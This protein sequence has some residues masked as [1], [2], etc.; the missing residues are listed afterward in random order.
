MTTCGLEL[1][2]NLTSMNDPQY[3]G[4][5]VAGCIWVGLANRYADAILENLAYESAAAYMN[6]SRLS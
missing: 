1:A 4:L 6:E 5:G 3:E 2:T